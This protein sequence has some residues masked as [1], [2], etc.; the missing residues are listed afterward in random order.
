MATVFYSL[1]YLQLWSKR[2]E[3]ITVLSFGVKLISPCLLQ[4]LLGAVWQLSTWALQAV[5]ST[6][7]NAFILPTFSIGHS[8]PIL[9][10]RFDVLQYYYQILIITIPQIVRNKII[11]ELFKYF[12]PPVLSISSWWSNHIRSSQNIPKVRVSGVNFDFSNR[13]I[14]K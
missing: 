6:R 12:K 2:T 7:T 8:S 1:V 13:K 10:K 4:V 5:A 3:P 9:Y 14:L 11:Q